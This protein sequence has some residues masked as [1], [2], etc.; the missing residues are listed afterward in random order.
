M[1][2]RTRK[3][4][5]TVPSLVSLFYFFVFAFPSEFNWVFPSWTSYYI[6]VGV[7][8]G[9]VLS[10]SI[11]LIVRIWRFKYIERTRKSGWTFIIV[12]FGSLAQLIYIWK[13]DKDFVSRNTQAMEEAQNQISE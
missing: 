2:S 5:L 8:N 1:M 13:K 11:Y 10:I 3:L 7:L 12:F 4:I 6:Q 9:G